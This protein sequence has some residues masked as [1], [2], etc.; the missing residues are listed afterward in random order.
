MAGEVPTEQHT[1]PGFGL[2]LQLDELFNRL[3]ASIRSV[4][5][6]TYIEFVIQAYLV[7]GQGSGLRLFVHTYDLSTFSHCGVRIR[8]NL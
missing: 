7:N 6:Q 3:W 8:C 2:E 4:V 1:L 5:T